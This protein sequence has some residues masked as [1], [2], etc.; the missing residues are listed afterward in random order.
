M[1]EHLDAVV[2]GIA[3]G[4]VYGLVAIGYSIVYAATRVFNLAQGDLL[5]AGVLLS[6]FLLAV[7]AWAGIAAFVAVVAVVMV[8]SLLEER[9]VVR[10]ALQ[11]S[12]SVGWFITTLAFS[13][14]I[15]NVVQNL[16]GNQ[17]ARAVPSPLPD[18]AIHLGP[19][20]I[21]PKLLLAIAALLAV[22][23]V[24]E[25]FYARTWWGR[26]MRATAEDREAASLRGID[27]RRVGAMAFAIGGIIAGV[28]GFVIAPIVFSD[29][30]I[31]LNYALKGFLAI[32]I[33]GFGSI[34]GA[35][36]GAWA[37]AIAEQL[38]DVH[39]SAAYEPVV[40]LGLLLLV[41]AVR[42]TGLF[43]AARERQV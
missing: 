18:T 22:T 4:S 5:M 35:V 17:E 42:P 2:L 3:I 24:V 11:R 14:I 12:D 13:G 8:V 36:L 23:A 25:V 31:G 26:A 40:G 20:V 34:R 10:P 39:F 38:G 29:V 16:Y 21:S 30:T 32:A 9:L 28:A 33:G 7:H 1:S 19:V 37:L 43:G 6:Y 27:P 15:R 41:L